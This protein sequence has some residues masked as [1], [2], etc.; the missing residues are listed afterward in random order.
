MK[1]LIAA[2]N[3]VVTSHGTSDDMESSSVSVS[4]VKNDGT[5]GLDDVQ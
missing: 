5:R 2:T 3:V 1:H 4:L